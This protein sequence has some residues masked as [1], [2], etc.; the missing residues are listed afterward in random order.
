MCRH[1]R[2]SVSASTSQFFYS[3]LVANH[4]S[5]TAVV[6]QI[7]LAQTLSDARDAWPMDSEDTCDM[8]MCDLESVTAASAL[9][10]Q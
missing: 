8:L 7:P 5:C 1:K 9:E 4:E 3:S 10:R 2:R 6:D